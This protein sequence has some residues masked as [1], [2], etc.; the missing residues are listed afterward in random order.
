MKKPAAGSLLERMWNIAEPAFVKEFKLFQP[1]PAD[2]ISEA[3]RTPRT[4]QRL[5]LD[6]E[7]PA[8]PPSA[9]DGVRSSQDDM[10]E[11]AVSF[12]WVGDMLRHIGTVVHRMLKRIAEDGISY[13]NP[14]RVRNLK[15]SLSSELASLGV[16]ADEL[17]AA[18]DRVESALA[19][20]VIG[21]R[22]RWLLGTHSHAACEYSISG[23]FQGGIVNVRIDR[24]FVDGQGVRWIIDYKSSSHEGAGMEEFLDNERERYR[25]QLARYRSLFSLLDNRPIRTALYFPLLNAWREVE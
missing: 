19:Q 14:E 8:M 18:T 10:E 12:H 13:W 9:G 22:G 21:D 5:P 4:I 20:A 1:P 17:P 24:T 16:S 6:W 11:T 2:Q 23:I 3:D 25:A 15:M 7:I